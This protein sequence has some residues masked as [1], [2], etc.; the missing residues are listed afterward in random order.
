TSA[1]RA[2][3]VVGADDTAERVAQARADAVRAATTARQRDEAAQPADAAAGTAATDTGT[4]A[5]HE[6][7]PAVEDEPT[8]VPVP[9]PPPTYTLKPSAPRREPA[10]LPADGLATSSA[11]APAGATT[12]ADDAATTADADRRTPVAA[13]AEQGTPSAAP[14]DLDA[15]L[16]RRRAVGE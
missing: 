11:A 16:A 9:V 2:T 12:L 10:P 8:W 13:A 1:P 5:A 15:I 7:A 14:L 3:G 4:P 6:P